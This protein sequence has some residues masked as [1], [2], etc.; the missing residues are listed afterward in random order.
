MAS[1]LKMRSGECCGKASDAEF[2]MLN[3]MKLLLVSAGSDRLLKFWEHILEQ[4]KSRLSRNSVFLKHYQSFLYIYTLLQ[5]YMF[6]V[7]DIEMYL[8]E[9]IIK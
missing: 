8:N 1:V 6:K 4:L 5:I 2:L 7:F 9:C 3:M